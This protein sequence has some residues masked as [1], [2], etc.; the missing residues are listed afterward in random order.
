[1]SFFILYYFECCLYVSFKDILQGHSG[2]GN[3]PSFPVQ[4]NYEI[5]SSSLS[6]ISTGTPSTKNNYKFFIIFQMNILTYFDHIPILKLFFIIA[7]KEAI[8]TCERK[9]EK[10]MYGSSLTLIN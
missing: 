10:S 4:Q 5:L 3:T 2:V 6:H 7:H 1:M 8:F 9:M